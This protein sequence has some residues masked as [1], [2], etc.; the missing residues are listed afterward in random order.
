[1]H[2]V[3]PCPKKIEEVLTKST[4]AGEVIGDFEKS[5]NPKFAGKSKETRKKMS[6]GAYYSMHPEKSNK[7]KD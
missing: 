6:L 1:M 4:S 3:K 5:D 2:G 7:K